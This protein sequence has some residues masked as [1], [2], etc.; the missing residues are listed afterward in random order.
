MCGTI[1]PFEIYLI[2][3]IVTRLCFSLE[4]MGTDCVLLEVRSGGPVDLGALLIHRN[5]EFYDLVMYSLPEKGSFSS[6]TTILS[7]FYI[8]SKLHIYFMTY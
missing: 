8:G 5:E 4:N 7:T 6:G 3:K 1:Q 2:A